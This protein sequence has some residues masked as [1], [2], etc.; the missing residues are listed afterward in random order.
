MV[1]LDEDVLNSIVSHSF[2][3]PTMRCYEELGEMKHG[4]QIDGPL[5]PPSVVEK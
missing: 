5:L 3:R 4:L 1:Q 2:L